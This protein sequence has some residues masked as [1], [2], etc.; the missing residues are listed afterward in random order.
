MP[1]AQQSTLLRVLEKKEIRRVGGT[2]SF[3]VNV[4]L[5]AATNNDLDQAMEAGHFRQDLFYRLS[6]MIIHLPSLRERV[7]DLP[8]LCNYFIKRYCKEHSLPL[9]KLSYQALEIL[10][11]RTWRGN[12]RE[13]ENVIEQAVFFSRRE[14]I[15]PADLP[16]PRAETVQAELRSLDEVTRAHIVSVL[17][18]TAGNKLKAARILG[19]PRPT[20][21]H[22]MK[23][24]GLEDSPLEPG[25]LR[26]KKHKS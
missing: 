2:R 24:L 11:N 4:R 10:C 14:L 1:L 6:R 3:H 19:I 16:I 17:A 22:R 5:I 26:G 13:L 12:V 7:E 20:L 25:P 23:R 18:H 21:Y 8:L 15:K 9:R